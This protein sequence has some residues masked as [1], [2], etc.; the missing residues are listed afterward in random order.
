MTTELEQL[1]AL[2]G[3]DTYAQAAAAIT[4]FNAFLDTAKQATGK[5][6]TGD[7]LAELQA[8]AARAPFALA[9]EKATGKTGD[10]AIGLIHAALQSH[11]ELPKAQARVTELE[12]KTQESD[13]N[14]LFAKAK[15][16][17][18]WTPA[19]E[20]KVREAFSAKEITLK[21]AESWLTNLP[22]IPALQNRAEAPPDGSAAPA[23]AAAL[24][25]N[26]KT[27]DELSGPERAAMRRE[28][29]QHYAAMRPAN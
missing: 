2:L 15:E 19:I 22:A 9:V 7:A 29:P 5:S 21:G 11:A 13:L 24:K 28:N 14:A 10:E 12:Q 26:G 6:G 4:N 20:A 8:R 16:E 23:A 27:W 17:K 18:K 3:A 25:W 1:L